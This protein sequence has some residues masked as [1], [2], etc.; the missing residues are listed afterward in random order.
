[1]QAMMVMFRQIS[2]CLNSSHFQVA[3]RA[4][5]LWNNDYIVSLV[6]QVR[7]CPRPIPRLPVTD[8]RSQKTGRE[9]VLPVARFCVARARV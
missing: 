4:L 6:A 5:F 9:A 3:E 8:S 1:M 7:P 2:R